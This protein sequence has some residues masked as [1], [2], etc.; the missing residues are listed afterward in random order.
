MNLSLAAAG[1]LG[2]FGASDDPW[3]VFDGDIKAEIKTL[4]A[5]ISV[6]N[7]DIQNNKE[8]FSNRYLKAWHVFVEEWLAFKKDY[9]DGS[10]FRA[11]SGAWIKVKD[12]KRRALEWSGV[13]NKKLNLTT[14]GLPRPPEVEKSDF[15]RAAMWGL[16]IGSAVGVLWLGSAIIRRLPSRESS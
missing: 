6:T 9:A 16:G 8:K 10:V 2:A 14:P 1:G 7:Q 5:V 15:V 13:V 4:S 3:I 11:R 12:F